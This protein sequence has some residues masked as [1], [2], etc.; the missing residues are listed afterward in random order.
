MNW[1][2]RIT[3]LRILLIPVFM[4]LLLTNVPHGAWFAAAVFG[5]AALTDS[6]DGYLARSYRQVTVM[7]QFLDPLADKL[8][9][10][11]ALVA[12]VDLGRLSAWIAILIISREFAVSGLRL[13]AMAEGR[14]IPASRFGK[15]KTLFQVIAIIGWIILPEVR[16][17][18][19]LLQDA[20]Y[21][22]AAGLLGLAV[23]LT[24]GSF[25]DY[26]FK[27]RDILIPPAGQESGR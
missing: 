13:V 27:S 16:V 20:I 3:I 24:L 14:V 12:L 19:P 18:P 22:L 9:V 4:V 17:G 23:V 5:L 26:F 6:V 11:A 1:A 7:G 2:N 15:T 21:L 10:S 8:L 25:F